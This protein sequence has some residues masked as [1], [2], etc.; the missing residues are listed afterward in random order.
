MKMKKLGR[1]GVSEDRTGST[2]RCT[3]RL[4]PFPSSLLFEEMK[5]IYGVIEY[6]TEICQDCITFFRAVPTDRLFR[7]DR[8]CW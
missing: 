5:R 1:I 2:L 4:T 3:G 7:Q 6:K 8:Q